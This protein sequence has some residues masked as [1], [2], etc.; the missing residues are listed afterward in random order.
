MGSMI[1]Q[2]RLKEAVQPVFG[3]K[4]KVKSA[5][6]PKYPYRAEK[7]YAAVSRAYEDMLDISLKRSLPS[8]MKAY[9][10]E[11][12]GD[13]RE[14]GISDFPS[15]LRR[16]IRE[17][18]IRIGDM[19]GAFGLEA[20]I[21]KIARMIQEHAIKEWSR[22]VSRTFGIRIPVDRYRDEVYE[23]AVQKW[24]SDNASQI[25]SMPVNTLFEVEKLISDAYRNGTAPGKLEKQ[26]RKKCASEKRRAEQWAVY[27][28]SSLNAFMAR[29]QHEDAGVRR[30]VWLSARDDR[31]RESHRSFDGKIYSWD[32][33]PAEWYRSKTRG[34]VY[35]GYRYNPGE[36]PGCRCCAVPVFDKD[37]LR[38]PLL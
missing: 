2:N 30:Y 37:T 33:P 13:S 18:A 4:K 7:E 38:L 34:I 10:R 22:S 26:I 1:D 8:V 9:K 20:K 23:Q 32:D 11:M 35:T 28:V 12:R 27:R 6:E 31:V 14:D 15:R 25:R 3:R 16:A 19:S 17:A 5:Y 21:E 36:A 24:I 29:M